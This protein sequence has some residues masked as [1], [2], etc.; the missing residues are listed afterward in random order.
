MWCQLKRTMRCVHMISPSFVLV[1]EVHVFNLH[2][3]TTV[4]KS[5]HST[6]NFVMFIKRTAIAY[7]QR[8]RIFV[9][10]NSSPFHK[11]YDITSEDFHSYQSHKLLAS[12]IETQSPVCLV[13]PSIPLFEYQHPP[14]II[15]GEKFMCPNPCNFLYYLPN[16]LSA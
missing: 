13:K 10:C 16:T 9:I 4:S 8:I 1:W 15:R 12:R 6:P 14:L 2:R 7:S 5:L 11:Y 3:S